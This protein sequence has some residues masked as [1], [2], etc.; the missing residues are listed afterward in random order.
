MSWQKLLVDGVGMAVR[1]TRGAWKM[2]GDVRRNAYS[3]LSNLRNEFA[4]AS[5]NNINPF[6]GNPL[7]REGG[8]MGEKFANWFVDFHGRTG[9]QHLL[10]TPK[11]I[12][13]AYKSAFGNKIGLGIVGATALMQD[14]NFFGNVGR[15]AVDTGAFTLGGQI[16][17]A[18][19]GAVLP[20]VGAPLGYLVGGVIGSM[21]PDA[22][23]GSM[24]SVAKY[25]IRQRGAL[26]NGPFYMDTEQAYTMRQR[27]SNIMRDNLMLHRRIMGQEAKYYH[28]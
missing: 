13:T 8:S 1:G 16:G 24:T 21:T 9:R 6:T 17:A 15:T 19:G 5:T 25:G 4:E 20:V 27:S 18:V 2:A 23:G 22:I 7:N 3:S 26:R 10:H 28:S 12:G 11:A 14:G